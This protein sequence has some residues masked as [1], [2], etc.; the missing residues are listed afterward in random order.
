M[1]AEDAL[2]A[3]KNGDL[4]T[5][6]SIS[7]VDKVKDQYGASC[8]HYAARA[9][10]VHIL[11]F[12]VKNRGLDS[13]LRSNVGATPAHDAAASGNLAALKWLLSNTP[14]KVDDQDGTG[15]TVVH[16][17]A[18]Y[19]HH[20]VLEWLL[21]NTNCDV[22]KK[23]GSG[24][25]PLHFAVV[26]G[27]MSCLKLLLSEAPR[28][29]NTQLNNGVT[30][31]YLACQEGQFDI[32]KYLVESGGNL[33]MNSY[34]GMTCVHTA[35]QLG[36]LECI[37]WLVGEQ[38]INPNVRDF[39]GTSPLHFAASR[40][41]SEIVSWLLKHGGAR[42]TL[43]NLGGSP[44]HNAVE[45]GYPKCVEVLLEN[46]CDKDITDNQ[47]L[48]ALELGIKCQQHQCVALLK[49]EVVP[50]NQPDPVRADPI[51]IKSK[52][53]PSKQEP[54]AKDTQQPAAFQKPVLFRPVSLLST[55]SS[56]SD[57][58]HFEP[59]PAGKQ[60][61][62]LVDVHTG[63]KDLAETGQKEC[64]SVKKSTVNSLPSTSCNNIKN[65]DSA[66]HYNYLPTIPSSSRNGARSSIDSNISSHS[67]GS[68][69]VFHIKE[70][71]KKSKKVQRESY[72]RSRTYSQGFDSCEE[73]GE[74]IPVYYKNMENG[75]DV[76]NQNE[77]DIVEDHGVNKSVINISKN[78]VKIN[79]IGSNYDQNHLTNGQV[80]QSDP[81]DANIARISISGSDNDTLDAPSSPPLPP[82]PTPP[83]SLQSSPSKTATSFPPPPP[84]PPSIDN[85]NMVTDGNSN[86]K[87]SKPVRDIQNNNY[88][89]PPPQHH[90]NGPFPDIATEILRSGGSSSLR[91]S[92]P[93]KSGGEMNCVFSFGGK[94][95][96][97]SQKS[98]TNRKSG[99]LTGEFDP[100]NFLDQVPTVDSS[101]V[102]IP[103][104]RRQVLAKNLA[105]KA[106]TDALEKQ[107]S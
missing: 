92:K 103:D 7:E 79:H 25:I 6:K 22:L 80:V 35:A 76:I 31:C 93:P 55:V 50:V 83:D 61:R 51:P 26:G 19:S 23:T 29:V 71:S 90:G 72:E 2:E 34:D 67:S 24:A 37:K 14:S 73:S 21:D 43:D 81:R 70:Q 74:I 91:K 87:N 69:K 9:D 99:N 13:F 5:L 96:K 102:Q 30:A 66:S 41:H 27:A 1:G 46:G 57:F 82:P 104:W 20:D 62:V 4:D 84:P 10:K 17:A 89:S 98:E 15:A 65:L 52:N 28:S 32:L 45:L 63:Q 59:K 33:K 58:G 68:N 11:E 53:L 12:L 39:D 107:K 18:R 8:L 40:G 101:G 47:G 56:E 3:A 44:L 64:V 75:N 16:L 36:R 85:S 86:I 97:A 78:N 49:G 42:I 94:S 54:I 88:S 95:S 38:K 48:T 60:H 77:V 106:M 105:Q 100:K